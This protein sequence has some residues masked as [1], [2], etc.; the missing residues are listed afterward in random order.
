MIV[1]ARWDLLFGRTAPLVLDVG[2][3]SGLFLLDSAR[4]RPEL[5]HLG[6]EL[7]RPLLERAAVAAAGI[8]NLKMLCGDAVEMLATQVAP[9]S[10]DELHVYH[11]QPY[12]DPREQHLGMLSERFLD[13]ARLVLKPTGTFF[14]QTDSRPYA[15]YLLEALPRHFRVEIQ[16]GPWPDAPSGRTQREGVAIRKGLTILRLRAF[17][18]EQPAE[19]EP[20]RPYFERGGIKRRHDRRRPGAVGAVRLPS[21]STD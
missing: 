8:P 4:R 15:A 13:R 19:G 20:P 2:C 10:V 12:R 7:N 14:V 9:A 5:D 17:P 6:I 11:P 21:A 18:R 3:G 1:P 16:E